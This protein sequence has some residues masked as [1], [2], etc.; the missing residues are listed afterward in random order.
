MEGMILDYQNLSEFTYMLLKNGFYLDTC[1]RPFNGEGICYK[2]SPEYGYGYCNIYFNSSDYCIC[3]LDFTLQEENNQSVKSNLSNKITLKPNKNSVVCSCRAETSGLKKDV[4]YFLSQK[5]ESIHFTGISFSNE[6]IEKQTCNFNLKDTSHLM[7]SFF[8]KHIDCLEPDMIYLFKQIENCNLT[9]DAAKIF[10]ESKSLEILSHLINV[11][12]KCFECKLFKA[13]AKEDVERLNDVVCFINQNF[14]DTLSINK[15]SKIA[16]MGTTK[17]KSTFK[18]VYSTTISAY[19]FDCRM[20]KAK[21]LLLQT[22]DTISDISRAIGY[23]K[24][25]SFSDAFRKHTGLLPSDFR[26]QFQTSII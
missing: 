9:G 13:V 16:C 26:R 21:E 23:K 24:S 20:N 10:Y 15:L 8:L 19:I 4:E 12:Q 14:N 3:V 5:N 25:G 18:R 6:F 17:L 1:E 11:P 22:N 2:L 7:H